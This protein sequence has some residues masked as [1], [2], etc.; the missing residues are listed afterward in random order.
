MKKS[1]LAIMMLVLFGITNLPAQRRPEAYMDLLPSVPGD[2][3]SDDTAVRGQF[4]RQLSE[5][6]NPLETELRRRHDEMDTKVNANKTKMETY[7]MQQTGIS[8]EMTQKMMALQEQK[9]HAA[10]EEQRKAIDKQ[11]KTLTDQMM[12]ESTNI[13][14]A[15]VQNLKTMDKAGKTA[16]ATAYSTEKKAEVMAE[17]EKYQEQN[18]KNMQKYN[19]LDKYNRLRD[20]IGAAQ[21]KYAR[22][23]QEID[24][25]EVGIKLMEMIGIKRK[26]LDDYIDEC[27]KNDIKQDQAKIDGIER[28]IN[29]YRRSY[30]SLLGPKYVENTNNYKNFILTAFSAYYRL[31]ELNNQVLLEQTGV[32]LNPEPGYMGLDI[33]KDYVSRLSDA[34]KYKIVG[35]EGFPEP[36]NE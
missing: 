1:L 26:E 21:G 5:V 23:F 29:G 13:S 3:C 25:N 28:E 16:W 32:D 24:E 10:N 4:V 36:A 11:M 12:Q 19:H 20:S 17:P 9:K 6:A 7:A 14:M 33:V 30:C 18:A 15:E 27:T 8:P 2:I 22:K 31:E 35:R 34:Y